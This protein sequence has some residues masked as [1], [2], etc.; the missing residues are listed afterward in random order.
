MSEKSKTAAELIAELQQDPAHVE[1]IRKAEA[2]ADA[3]AKEYAAAAVGLLQDLARAGFK[4]ESVGA[5]RHR[6]ARYK[7]AI[8]ILLEWL[9]RVRYPSLKEDIVRTVSVPWAKPAAA[10]ALVTEFR[11]AEDATGTGL[12]WAIAN[13]LE[14]VADDSVFDDIVALLRDPSSGKAREMLAMALARLTPGRAIPVLVN[15]LGDD[16]V[17]GHAAI[18]LGKLRAIEA[19]PE[20]ERLLAHPKPWVRKEVGR[21]LAAIRE[22]ESK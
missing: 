17:A 6:R 1:R 19:V 12:R 10:R 8:P 15:L 2:Q 21:A 18:A 3:N 5:L 16:D 4:V 11:S 14:V 20:L 13:G 22:R 9:P 7:A